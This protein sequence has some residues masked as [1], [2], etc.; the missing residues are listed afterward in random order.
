MC[1]CGSYGL[2]LLVLAAALVSGGIDY[3]RLWPVVVEADRKRRAMM[4]RREM[5]ACTGAEAN[6]IFVK[7]KYPRGAS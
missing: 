5:V 2:R 3:A 1:V 6:G 4:V 7:G